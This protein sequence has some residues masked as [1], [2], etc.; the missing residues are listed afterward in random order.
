MKPKEQRI[1]NLLLRRQRLLRGWSLQRVADE[2][3]TLPDSEGRV[4][5]INLAMVS[6]WEMG[7]K[8]PSP[9]YQE[10]LCL[11]YGL[12]ADKLGFMDG[13]VVSHPHQAS[14]V[15]VLSQSTTSS[16]HVLS[17]DPVPSVTQAMIGSFTSVLSQEQIQTIDWLA[18]DT[19]HTLDNQL[20]AW[21]TLSAN[22]LSMLLDAG[23][24]AEN[25]LN[26]MRI[27][28]QCVQELPDVTRRKL[29]QLSGTAPIIG[30]EF[31]IGEHVSVSE[32][33][34]ERLTRAIGKSIIDGWKLFHTTST[35]VLLTIAEAL[36]FLMQQVHALLSA[37][38]RCMFYAS[39][40]RL[41]GA[42]L[43]F[44]AR[45]HEAMKAFNQ[46][47][48]AGLEANDPWNMAESLSWQG[49]VWKACGMQAKAIQTTEAALRLT[50]RHEKE[51]SLPLR[52]RLFAHWAES[53]ALLHQPGIMRE[54][55]E[56]SADLLKYLEMNDEFD[57][58]TWKQYR[59][60]CHFYIGETVVADKYF[61]QALEE[62]KPD[63]ILQKGYTLLLQAQSRL[64]VGEIDRSIAVA[65]ASL[66]FIARIDSP[67]I[68]RG[69]M[70]YMQ[71]VLYLSSNPDT[72]IQ[73]FAAEAQQLMLHTDSMVP[74]YLEA[75]I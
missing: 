70:D 35:R 53:A 73:A 28:L 25:V 63:W 66:P 13:L 9:F 34:K 64:K 49:G 72:S 50:C 59:A 10:R 33:E 30:T 75:K 48:I 39:I 71:E 16:H 8:K 20:G 69:L 29:L 15:A 36:L 31:L 54:K 40:Y 14:G 45:Y 1:P 60:V 12:A 44:L 24:S 7:K 58:A 65:R 43:F 5:G 22:H 68:N 41:K 11:I 4:P 27:V 26:A 51:K 56:A 2:I 18:E 57:Y 23:L 46:S 21:L 52:A 55:L 19:Q 61:Q 37:S 47:Y 6:C 42:A 38:P 62:T 32:E 67:L 17:S 74:R 3:C